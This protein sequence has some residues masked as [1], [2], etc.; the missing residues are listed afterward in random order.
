MT[1]A[2]EMLVPVAFELR[3]VFTT[4][5]MG[6]AVDLRARYYVDV[7]ENSGRWGAG[8]GLTFTQRFAE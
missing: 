3:R 1:T 6:V 8:L 4:A 7:P 2:Q 5:S